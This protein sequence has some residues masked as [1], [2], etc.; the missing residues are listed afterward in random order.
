MLSKYKYK[1]ELHAHTSPASPCSRISPEKMVETYLREGYASVAITNHFMYDQQD[2]AEKVKFYLDDYHKTAEIGKKSGLNIILG[3]E[4]R[5]AGSFN[6]YLIYGICEDE[7]E[8]IDKLL[9]GSIDDF[10]KVYKNEKN[11]ILQA[12]PFRDNITLANPESLDGIEVFNLHP[13][14]NS[15]V[16]FAAQYA[17]KHNMLVSAGTD[18]HE[19]GREAMCSIMTEKPL[20][21]SYEVAEIIKSQ[22]FIVDISGYKVVI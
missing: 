13:G 18:F 10:Y 4:L 8:G 11:V 14:H 1:T 5:F 20:T 3:A 2:S 21:D 15:R 17:K 12:H 9:S 22:D 19:P 7:L 16:G 6:D